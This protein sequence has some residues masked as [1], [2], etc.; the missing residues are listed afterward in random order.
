MGD[1]RLKRIESIVPECH[2]QR[3]ERHIGECLSL[4]IW[5]TSRI[6]KSLP[7]CGG[8]TQKHRFSHSFPSVALIPHKTRAGL[9]HDTCLLTVVLSEVTHILRAVSLTTL[10]EK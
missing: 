6:F 7:P 4:R 9:A 1:I 3:T 10:V 8:G 5:V 2:T